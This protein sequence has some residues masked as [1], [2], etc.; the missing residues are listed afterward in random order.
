MFSTLSPGSW[1]AASRS[2][3]RASSPAA[4]AY[5]ETCLGWIGTIGSMPSSLRGAGRGAERSGAELRELSLPA[6][7]AFDGRRLAGPLGDAH[8]VDGREGLGQV[9]GAPGSPAGAT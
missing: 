4:S 1:R 9:L 6:V 5:S 7:R 8:Q 3:S 2:C